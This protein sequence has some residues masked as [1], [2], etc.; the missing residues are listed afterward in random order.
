MKTVVITSSP[1]SAVA[2]ASRINWMGSSMFI[3]QAPREHAGARPAPLARSPLVR[4][5]GRGDSLSYQPL[6]V[7]ARV[8][9]LLAA[10]LGSGRKH[11]F[12]AFSFQDGP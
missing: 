11:R 1:G 3:Q 5:K 12:E 6:K 8:R 7:P 4:K 10:G 2:A 9:F